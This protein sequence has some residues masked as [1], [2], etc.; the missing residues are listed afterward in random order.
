MNADANELDEVGTARRV[1]GRNG[2]MPGFHRLPHFWGQ[3][4]EYFRNEEGRCNTR[5][6]VES[7]MHVGSKSDFWTY[8]EQRTTRDAANNWDQ[9]GDFESF[10]RLYYQ[11]EWDRATLIAYENNLTRGFLAP[12]KRVFPFFYNC[13][14]I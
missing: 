3:P 9:P 11:M 6:P 13:S 7:I 8:N 12:Q 2:W 5:I 10:R 1:H 14:C 4:S